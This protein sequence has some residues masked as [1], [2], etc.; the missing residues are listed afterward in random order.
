MSAVVGDLVFDFPSGWL[1]DARNGKIFLSSSEIPSPQF[2]APGTA[3]L[4]VSPVRE[5]DGA[6]KRDLDRI[7]ARER[8][9]GVQDATWSFRI[10]NEQ[11]VFVRHIRWEAKVPGRPPMSDYVNRLLVIWMHSSTTR[12]YL[13]YWKGDPRSRE[14]EDVCT[15]LILS[16]RRAVR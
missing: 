4:S 1:G 7:V 14:Y 9:N 13:E 5:T 2:P 8:N 15:K 10:D 12:V 6:T 11:K 3:F 16:A